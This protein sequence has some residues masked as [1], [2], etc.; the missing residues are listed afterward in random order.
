MA[1]APFWM[2]RVYRI[3]HKIT[4]ISGRLIT[5]ETGDS[6]TVSQEYIDRYHPAVG[7]Y[8]VVHMSG[9]E[10]YHTAA[11]IEQDYVVSDC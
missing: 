3:A 7:G 8:Y 1:K 5:C 9:A 6:F 11:E 10:D 4:A 2:V